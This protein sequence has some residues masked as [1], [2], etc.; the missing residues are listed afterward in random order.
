[1]IAV[2][3]AQINKRAK[4]IQRFDPGNYWGES[5][6]EG[7]TAVLAFGSTI[8]PARAAARQLAGVGRQ[9]RVIALR[10]LSPLPVESLAR[11]LKGVRRIIVIEQNH[12][13]QLYHHLIGQKAIPAGAESVARPGPL[14]FRPSEIASYV[15]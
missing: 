8:G 14:P 4:K 9:I 15:V 2:L 7:D 3:V 11:A 6:G 5:W 12:G 10:V 1:M 13:A